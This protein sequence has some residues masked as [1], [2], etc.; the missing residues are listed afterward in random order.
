M[1]L[2]F[3][4]FFVFFL[5]CA[6]P[7]FLLY[8]RFD[9]LL[10]VRFECITLEITHFIILFHHLQRLIHTLPPF[11][12]TVLLFV[13]SYIAPNLLALFFVEHLDR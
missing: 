13:S 4:E 5:H 3:Q 12:P 8:Y 10:S 11:F 9:V 6:L 2:L 7:H 1:A